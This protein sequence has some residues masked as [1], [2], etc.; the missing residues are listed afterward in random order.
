MTASGISR[1]TRPAGLRIGLTSKD[2]H[3]LYEIHGTAS[4][5]DLARRTGLSYLQVYNLVHR[6]VQTVNSH[7]YRRLFGRPAR[8][9]VPLKIDGTC[10]RALVNL[11]LYLNEGLTRTDLYNEFYPQNRLANADL[12]IFNGKIR[13]VDAR[14]EHVMR[15]KFSRQGVAGRL[16]D[17]WLDEFAALPLPEKHPY[18]RIRPVLT[19]LEAALGLHPTY[20]LNQSVAR[21]EN[22]ELKHVSRRVMARAAALKVK[23]EKALAARSPKELDKIRETLVGGK[24]G[25]TL[26]SQIRAELRFLKHYAGKS[27][28]GYLGRS[29]WT[30]EKGHT[31]HI[32][33]WRARKILADCDRFIMQNPDLPVARLP[34]SRRAALSKRLTDTLMA[35]GAQ[36]L[37]AVEGL[38][39]E[40]QLLKPRRARDDYIRRSQNYTAFDRASRALGMKPKAFDLMV[41]RHPDIFRSVGKFDKRWYLPDAY[42]RELMMKK[43]FGLIAAKYASTARGR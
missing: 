34:Q 24:P 21:Y 32:A 7:H 43:E 5:K 18:E 9:Q 35:R 42:L 31:R 30:Y 36:L 1:R 17:A 10:F 13:K 25:Q 23:T 28:R 41:A 33:T 26:Y 39:L 11:W 22:G 27:I 20:L 16:L 6:R 29:T 19:Y 4:V 2:I 38:A 15:E 37:S 14:L 8:N 3:E 40:K 12:R